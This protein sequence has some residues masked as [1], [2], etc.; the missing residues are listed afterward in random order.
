MSRFLMKKNEIEPK[1]NDVWGLQS[2]IN[3]LFDAFMSPFD[4]SVFNNN[5]VMPKLDIAELKDKY[6][7]KAELPGIDEND[8]NLSIEDGILK[9]SGE[10]KSETE[11]KEKG[12]YLKECSYGSFSRSVRLPDNILEDKIAAKFNKGVLT[13]DMPKKAETVS[14]SRKIEISAK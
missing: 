14:K 3:R 12:Y 7:I 11:N 4:E 8:I 9:I 13:I 6:E 5:K 1:A 2:D 10:K